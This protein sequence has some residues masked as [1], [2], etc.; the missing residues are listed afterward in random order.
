MSNFYTVLAKYY[1]LLY[2]HKDYK[3][4]VE[5]IR[6]VIEKHKISSGFSLLDVACGTGKHIEILKEH[7]TV[8]GLDLSEDMLEVARRNNSDVAFIQSDM[9]RMSLGMQFDVITCLFGSINYIQTHEDLSRTFKVFS[10]HL[11]QGGIVV[12]EPMFTEDN[13]YLGNLGFTTVDRD[14]V[15]LARM[16]LV[17]REGDLVLLDFHFLVGTSEG[18]HYYREPSPMS[19]FS[20]NTLVTIME[21]NGFHVEHEKAESMKSAGL[22]I[23]IK[24]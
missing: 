1:D 14:D 22:F 23:G 11:N 9:T 20:H 10:D 21:D 18:I 24:Q 3:S 16:N 4:E 6:Q 5:N 8:T 2:A 15:K 13:L 19:V 7:Y 17:R 12:F